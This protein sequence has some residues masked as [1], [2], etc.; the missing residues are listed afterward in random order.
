M[1]TAGKILL[2]AVVLCCAAK[3]D[4]Q[5]ESAVATSPLYDGAYVAPMASYIFNEK[6]G[7]AF[8]GGYGGTF[9]VGYRNGWW[10]FEG[11]LVVDSEKAKKSGAGGSDT[12]VWGATLNGLV[13]PFDSLPGLFALVGAGGLDV[14][15]YPTIGREYSLTTVETGAG[16][17]VPMRVGRYAFGIR[18]DARYRYGLRGKSVGPNG[19]GDY[20]IPRHFGDVLLNVGLQLPVGLM[21]I[22]VAPKAEPVAVV[23]VAAPVDSD[24]DGV[25]DD[26]DQCPNTPAGTQVNDVGCPLPPPCKPPEAGQKVDLSGCAVGDSIVLRGVNFE[27]DQAKLTV[28]A[29]TILD[30]VAD[31]LTAAPGIAVEVDGHTDSRGSDAYNQALSER[32]AQSVMQYLADHGVAADRMSAKGFGE[33]QPV[34]DN[35]TEDG[36]ELNRRV[37]LKI[38]GV[39]SA[40]AAAAT[41]SS[42]DVGQSVDGAPAGS[43]ASPSSSDA[44]DAGSVPD[45][46]GPSSALEPAGVSGSDVSEPQPDQ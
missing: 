29:Q 5:D 45:S 8:D 44:G 43:A 16:Y 15:R 21:P 40:D 42:A 38:V 1:R 12:S 24:G 6:G 18:M 11:S 14:N 31:A 26:K 33:T 4:A 3:A 23:P 17:L 46:S 28:N 35:D 37:E 7:D 10:A 39:G 13:F 36:R 30:G 20:D 2:T 25:T 19:S 9:A 27:Y 34:A 22:P 32:R 41:E